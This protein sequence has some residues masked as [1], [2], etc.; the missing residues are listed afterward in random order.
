MKINFSS[1]FFISFAFVLFNVT[2]GGN[3]LISVEFSYNVDFEE[4]PHIDKAI[5]G[6]LR[7]YIIPDRHP[8]KE[9]LDYIFKSRRVTQDI[10]AFQEAGFSIISNRPRSFI[11]V[12]KHPDLEKYIIKAYMDTE[13]RKK[14]GIPGWKWLTRR[15]LGAKRIAYTIAKNKMKYFT[16]A[17]K[18]IYPLPPEPSPLDDGKHV[19]QIVLLVATDMQLT[20]KKEN[21]KAWYNVITKEHLQELFTIMNLA[22]GE[23]YRPDNIHY[24]KSGQFAFIDTEYPFLGPDY[25]SIRKYLSPSMLEYWDYLV[26]KGEL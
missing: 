10:D 19:R 25:D 6:E 16:V 22:K 18:W 3:Q 14:R 12:A 7:K 4:N 21:L 24:T 11:T 2:V 5:K 8:I 13:L 1:L 17:R 9:K 23:S 15:C 26:E 20:S